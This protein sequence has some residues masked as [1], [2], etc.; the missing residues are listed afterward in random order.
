MRNCQKKSREFVTRL[1][2]PTGKGKGSLKEKVTK[3]V[4]G[5]EER[6]PRDRSNVRS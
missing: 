3:G 6:L 1:I 5:R 4:T 2:S